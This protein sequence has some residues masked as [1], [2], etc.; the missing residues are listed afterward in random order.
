M[1]ITSS[2]VS[3]YYNV[4]IAWAFYYLGS[5]FQ[6]PLPW[7]CDAPGNAYLCQVSGPWAGSI[8]GSG[9]GMRC[10]GAR[11]RTR[12]GQVVSLGRSFACSR[13]GGS[14][15]G[16]G[17]EGRWGWWQWQLVV[18]VTCRGCVLQN[19]SGIVSWVSASE[20]FWK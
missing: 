12:T 13:R 17:R 15:W 16:W 14:G 8:V 5:S 3:L 18:T 10:C 7:S 11:R 19:A 6:S 4:I 2:L 9:P 20:V 1:L